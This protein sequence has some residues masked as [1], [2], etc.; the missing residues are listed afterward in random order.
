VKTNTVVF[1]YPDSTMA[2]AFRLLR[3]RMQFFTKDAKAPVI[4]ITSSVPEEGKT[5]IAINLASVYSLLEKKTILVG[6]DLRQPKIFQDFNLKNE[7]GVSTWLIGQD[8]LQ[9]IIQGTSF[10]N[11][12]VIASG[13]VP[14]N[15][16]ELIALEKTE[17]LLKSLKERYDYIIIDSPPIGLVSDTFHLASLA[18]A[19]LLVVRSGYTLR[20]MLEMTLNEIR[21]SD[22]KSVSLVINDI[23]SNSKRYGYGQ[24]YGYTSDKKP[25]GKRLFKTKKV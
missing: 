11:L 2:E 19:C 12:S 9:D 4:L 16:S 10:Q 22:M 24:K 1:E 3:S 5:H 20:D 23:Q 6:F 15:P 14:P 13:P 7:K 18:D 21:A 17:I 25:S 8:N